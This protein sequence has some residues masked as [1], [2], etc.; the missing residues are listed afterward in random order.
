MARY[1]FFE[2][3][4]KDGGRINEILATVKGEG[5]QEIRY[6]R[7]AISCDL[8]T[9]NYPSPSLVVFGIVVVPLVLL[10]EDVNIH[11]SLSYCMMV[12]C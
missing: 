3:T 6:Y 2:D 11:V 5:E 1:N 8:P 12:N 9:I 10:G 7:T 4:G